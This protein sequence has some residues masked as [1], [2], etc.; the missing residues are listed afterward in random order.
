VRHVWALFRSLHPFDRAVRRRRALDGK[1]RSVAVARRFVAPF[2][3]VF[4][5]NV[6]PSNSPCSTPPHGP[7]HAQTGHERP[8]TYVN[9]QYYPLKDQIWKRIVRRDRYQAG[10]RSALLA[11]IK[12]HKTKN[13]L[14]RRQLPH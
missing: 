10:I 3:A 2:A 12:V 8:H 14:Q 6:R 13:L 9:E 11:N 7:S 5:R 1:V 4:W